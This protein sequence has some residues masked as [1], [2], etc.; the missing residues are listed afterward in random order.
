MRVLLFI[1][2]ILAFLSGAAPPADPFGFLISAVFFSGAGIVDAIVVFKKEV[3]RRMD[4]K[5][6]TTG[7]ESQQGLGKA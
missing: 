3:L 1:S 7:S 4:A 5:M 2:A 6:S